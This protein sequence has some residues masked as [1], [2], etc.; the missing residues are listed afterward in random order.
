MKQL[1]RLWIEVNKRFLYSWSVWLIRTRNWLE[2]NLKMFKKK[3]NKRLFPKNTKRKGTFYVPSWFNFRLLLADLLP[4]NFPST[5][6][7][8][9]Y[10]MYGFILINYTEIWGKGKRSEEIINVVLHYESYFRYLFYTQPWWQN[11]IILL[12]F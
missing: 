9:D 2:Q 4:H 12:K 5:V 6:F 10:R 7:M 8:A 1:L 11:I 3:I